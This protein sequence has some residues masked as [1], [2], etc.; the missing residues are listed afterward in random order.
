MRIFSLILCL[1]ATATSVLAQTSQHSGQPSWQPVSAD[2]TFS[3]G[4]M[5]A[6]NGVR[7][8]LYGV[9]SCLRGTT[10]TDHAGDRKDC[11]EASMFMLAS[12]MQDLKPLCYAVAQTRDGATQFVI[13]SAV[14]TKGGN[15]GKTLD[16]GTM[17]ISSG[18]GF[19]ALKPD[20]QPVNMGYAVAQNMAEEKRKGL[21]A[22]S[23]LPDPNAALL[24][25][26]P[27]PQQ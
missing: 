14:L 12:L 25:A 3:T 1:L 8:R 19:A 27:Q 5:W 2:S 20:G 4:D 7:Y 13:C 21:W 11:G 26:L 9:Q 10:Y 24:Q 16:I 6:S 22:F 23:D 15:A 18:F 17:L